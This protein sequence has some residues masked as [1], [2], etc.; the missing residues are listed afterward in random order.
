MEQTI[1]AERPKEFWAAISSL[2]R[3]QP[4]TALMVWVYAMLISGVVLLAFFSPGWQ[5]WFAAYTFII[6]GFFFLFLTSILQARAAP[7]G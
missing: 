7:T 2:H 4:V 5:Y 1:K 6:G 3:Q